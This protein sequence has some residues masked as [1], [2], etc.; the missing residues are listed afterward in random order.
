VFPG[1]P[2]GFI[3]HVRY[4]HDLDYVEAFP[5]E[6]SPKEVFEQ[7]G[8]EV[9]YRGVIVHRGAAGVHP[10]LAGREGLE[11]LEPPRERIVEFYR[12]IRRRKRRICGFYQKTPWD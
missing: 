3:V 5:R 12:H 11:R 2:Y 9:P 10:D 4:V 7:E 8:P 6:V 1:A